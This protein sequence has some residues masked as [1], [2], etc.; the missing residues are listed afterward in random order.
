[1]RTSPL[2]TNIRTSL[3]E[4]QIKEVKKRCNSH[5]SHRYTIYLPIG[6]FALNTPS[7]NSCRPHLN[8][9]HIVWNG[10]QPTTRYLFHPRLP[11]VSTYLLLFHYSILP[12][13]RP[14]PR[15]APAVLLVLQEDIK[16]MHWPSWS[17][18]T[19]PIHRVIARSELPQGNLRV[20][21]RDTSS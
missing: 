15:N 8:R 13:V 14:T 9:K 10:Q 21:N 4:R 17:W 19:L 16:V 20:E 11:L 6:S 7:T 1:M 12:I 2:T 3:A 5:G 18:M